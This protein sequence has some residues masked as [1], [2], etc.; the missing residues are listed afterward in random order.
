MKTYITVKDTAWREAVNTLKGAGITV[1]DNFHDITV[2]I[3][4][5]EQAAKVLW[6]AQILHYI[7]D[8]PCKSRQSCSQEN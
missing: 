5:K 8:Q 1:I 3:E 7:S 2:P 6:A 4:Q